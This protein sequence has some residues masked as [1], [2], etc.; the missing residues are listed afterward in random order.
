MQA[1]EG[2]YCTH[3]LVRLD[4]SH[5]FWNCKAMAGVL[6]FWKPLKVHSI[7]TIFRRLQPSRLHPLSVCLLKHLTSTFYLVT[8]ST[9]PRLV[10]KLDRKLAPTLGDSTKSAYGPL[11][12]RAYAS[13]LEVYFR[14]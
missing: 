10:Q 9:A 13:R 12:A 2:C 14:R 1:R 4:T 11:P 5:K 6:V 7:S 3:V 8:Y